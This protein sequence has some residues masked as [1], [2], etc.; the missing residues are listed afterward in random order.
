MLEAN[1]TPALRVAIR[2]RRQEEVQLFGPERRPASLPADIPIALKLRN[3]R[4]SLVTELNRLL[5][6][7][8]TSIAG[9]SAGRR[10][11]LAPQPRRRPV[12]LPA[13]RR[14]GPP[15]IHQLKV[16][17]KGGRPAIWR[18][19][20]VRSDTT[21]AQLHQVLQIAM[22]WYNSHLHEFVADGVQYGVP[23]TEL[24][25]TAQDER[26]VT[27]ADVAPAAGHRLLYEYDFGDG[28][29]HDVLVEK[30]F[31]AE[32]GATYPVCV[33]GRRACPPEDV[34]GPWGYAEL[35]EILNDPHDAE[36]QERVE[37][38]GG[39]FDPEQFDIENVNASLRRLFGK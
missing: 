31:E 10:T 22:G 16:T 6:Q 17:L 24:G 18:R 34:G 15:R 11:L 12:R 23:D 36:Y 38:V 2:Q 37:W 26:A 3:V 32:P 29:E 19:V 13:R 14:D 5:V 25:L 27:L 21:L 28:W 8:A 35:L 39:E 33:K 1:V 20:L 4:E 30:L 7:D 9:A